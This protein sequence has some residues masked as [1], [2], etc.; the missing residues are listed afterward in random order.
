MNNLVAQTFG[1][2]LDAM[3]C[4]RCQLRDFTVDIEHVTA[5]RQWRGTLVMEPFPTGW[6]VVKITC[7]SCGY[8]VSQRAYFKDYDMTGRDFAS[9]R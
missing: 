1:V 9:A 4:T 6:I 3:V 7:H 8:S 2:D 5:M